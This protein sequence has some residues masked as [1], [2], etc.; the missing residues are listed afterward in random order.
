MKGRIAWVWGWIALLTFAG[1]TTAHALT[2][3]VVPTSSSVAVGATVGVDVVASGLGDGAAPSLSSFDVD[4]TFDP[5]LVTGDDVSLGWGL[6]EP[7]TTALVMAEEVGSG[8]A[9]AWVISLLS[10]EALDARQGAS[11]LLGTV[12]FIA[13]APG[14]AEFDI[15]RALLGDGLGLP[16]TVDEFVGTTITI[17]P[18][19]STS[20]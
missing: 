20:L 15:T 17:V 3:S 18:E 6:G 2:L 11:V 8:V 9:R 12:F 1:S 7:G 16:L 10:P 13:N 5:L 14:S 4:L 19:P